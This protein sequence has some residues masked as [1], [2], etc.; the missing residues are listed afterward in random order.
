M[1]SRSTARRKVAVLGATGMVGRRMARLLLHHPDFA[2]ERVVGSGES[3]GA[4]YGAV[5]QAK[6]A[7]LRHHYGEFWN[8]C[9]I[10]PEL[11]G[12]RVSSFDDLLASDCPIVFSSV[13]DRAG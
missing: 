4:A 10:P 11:A 1:N 13:P 3:A 7:A 12:M 5:W 2:L 9:A 8:E 6:E